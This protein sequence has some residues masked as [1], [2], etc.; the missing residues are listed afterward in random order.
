MNLLS[1]R[2]EFQA[3]EFAVHLG[4]KNELKSALLKL[5][6]VFTHHCVILQL[7]HILK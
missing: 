4:K 5:Y 7:L 3:D 1:R 2:F 6:K